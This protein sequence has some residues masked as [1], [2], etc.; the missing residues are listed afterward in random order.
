M[1]ITFLWNL[2]KCLLII[3]GIII[4]L[5]IIINVIKLPFEEA[6][7]EQSR[8]EFDDA[9]LELFKEELKKETKNTTKKSNKNDEN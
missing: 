1:I 3:G 2:L 6:K 4:T 7:A 9:L 8:K 5:A